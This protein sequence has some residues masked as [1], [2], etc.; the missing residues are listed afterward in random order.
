[1]KV[2]AAHKEWRNKLL[3]D[4]RFI[5][6]IFSVQIFRLAFQ[7]FWNQFLPNI[8]SYQFRLVFGSCTVWRQNEFFN[9][10]NKEL[11]INYRHVFDKQ[12]QNNEININV[13]GWLFCFWLF[14]QNHLKHHHVAATSIKTEIIFDALTLTEHL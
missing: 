3:N 12:W 4:F 6:M 1:M 9:W 10:L 13:S 2:A 8:C 7:I 11:S 5:F 14:S